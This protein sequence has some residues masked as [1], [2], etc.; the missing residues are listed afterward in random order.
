M[1]KERL[2][3][4]FA[5]HLERTGI[6]MEIRLPLHCRL[7]VAQTALPGKSENVSFG[8]ICVLLPQVI[9]PDPA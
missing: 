4:D 9:H 3:G 6:R 7:T 2:P 5:D 1:N 8:G